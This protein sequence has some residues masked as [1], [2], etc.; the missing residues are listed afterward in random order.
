MIIKVHHNDYSVA[1]WKLLSKIVSQRFGFFFL[2]A[3][4]YPGQQVQGWF[5]TQGTFQNVE[6]ISWK[7]VKLFWDPH[8][9]PVCLQGCKE[10]N[11]WSAWKSTEFKFN[12]VCVFPF[13]NLS[14][15]DGSEVEWRTLGA[16]AAQVCF[17]RVPWKENAI[18]GYLFRG[19]R[20]RHAPGILLIRAMAI[21]FRG[22]MAGIAFFFLQKGICCLRCITTRCKLSLYYCVWLIWAQINYN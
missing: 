4:L 10:Q 22:E 9:E 11:T 15:S 5:A 6:K 13:E 7:C 20:G 3:F 21:D 12:A 1:T 16:E 8:P 17:D 14:I 2:D 18:L 19:I